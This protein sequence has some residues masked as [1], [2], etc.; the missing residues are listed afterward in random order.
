[1]T[2]KTPRFPSVQ[3]TPEKAE[4]FAE[5]ERIVKN[6]HGAS[7]K[8]KDDNG[9]F[10][11]PFGVL[12]SAPK[13]FVP[14]LDYTLAF[15]KLPHVTPKERELAILAAVSV[16]KSEF[17]TYAHHKIGI[18]QGLSQTQVEHASSGR[19]PI[20]GLSDREESIYEL[21]LSLARGFGIIDDKQFD[22]AVTLLGR[23][24]VSQVAQL[25]GGYILVS[26]L[27]SVGDV[28][29]PQS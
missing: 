8:V 29:A 11:G 6:L 26:L 27:V 23:E 21:S 22:S 3:D 24:G 17:V 2:T 4:A 9:N 18:A 19:V 20:E 16:T 7:F 15:F 25:V 28:R 10:L 5:V 13:T 14:Y 1:M 12:S